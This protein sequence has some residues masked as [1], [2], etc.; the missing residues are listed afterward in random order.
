MEQSV[1]QESSHIP[2]IAG[3]AEASSVETAAAIDQAVEKNDDPEVAEILDDAASDVGPLGEHGGLDARDQRADEPARRHLVLL[4][5]QL[6][7]PLDRQE[8]RHA[9]P[10]DQH[11]DDQDGDLG[12]EADAHAG[13]A[14]MRDTRPAQW[15]SRSWR[16]SSLPAASRGKTSWNETTRGTL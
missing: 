12:G 4:D 15:G 2:L 6:A 8:G 1:P 3:S 11:Q 14:Q 16:L 10:H 5:E 13:G 9:E 7:L